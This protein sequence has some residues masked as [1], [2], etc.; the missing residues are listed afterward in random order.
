MISYDSISDILKEYS[1]DLQ[2]I[3]EEDKRH[4]EEVV[5]NASIESQTGVDYG[6]GNGWGIIH[7]DLWTGK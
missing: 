5:E 1:G 2:A 7:G 3:Y 4:L 6:K